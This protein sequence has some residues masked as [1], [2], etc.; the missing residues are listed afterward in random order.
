VFHDR[1]YGPRDLHY[2]TDYLKPRPII[3]FPK[4]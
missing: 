3:T 1:A 4:N 2:G